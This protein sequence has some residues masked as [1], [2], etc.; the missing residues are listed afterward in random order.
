MNDRLRREAFAIFRY[1]L[2][3]VIVLQSVATIM[4]MVRTGSSHEL[5]VVLILAGVEAAAA[6]LL[7]STATLMRA[8]YVLLAVFCL[9]FLF[10]LFS[11]QFESTLLIYA[12]SVWL[13][14][15]TKSGP[16]N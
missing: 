5:I 9:A 15:N 10:H 7:L 8:G 13:V 16:R 3:I 11:G 2:S 12:A 14:M 6:I 4:E 1:T